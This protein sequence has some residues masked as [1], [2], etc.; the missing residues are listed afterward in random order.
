MRRGLFES[1]GQEIA[2]ISLARAVQLRA[3]G[4]LEEAG[5]AEVIDNTIGV[6]LWLRRGDE[7]PVA[8]SRRGQ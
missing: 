6:D 3:E 8:G 7:E 5:E 2:L 4:S 1:V